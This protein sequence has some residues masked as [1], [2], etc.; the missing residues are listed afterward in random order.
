MRNRD[1]L[2]AQLAA[3]QLAQRASLP[4]DDEQEL[5]IAAAAP[6]TVTA[7]PDG[8]GEAFVSG[9]Q[10]L[11]RHGK[12]ATPV[13]GAEA[14]RFVQALRYLFG[15]HPAILAVLQKEGQIPA[16]V[17]YF[18]QQPGGDRKV[19]LKIAAIRRDEAPAVSPL[20][21][22]TPKPPVEDATS[23]DDLVDRA[24]A[25]RTALAAS[26]WPRVVR[27]PGMA[28]MAPRPFDNFLDISEAQLSGRPLPAVSDE[29]KRTFQTDLSVR[30]LAQAV[31]A[32]GP[33][34]LRRATAMLQTLR[35]Q[36]RSRAYL[37][38]VFEANDRATL[39]ERDAA[40]ALFAD[41]LRGNPTLVGAYKDIGDFYFRGFDTPHA[42]RSWNVARTLAPLYPP[43]AA[44]G[45]YER[46]LTTRFPEYFQ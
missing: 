25:T 17:T 5:S 32:K 38:S 46:S 37:L 2:R 7:R 16:N 23:L 4:L 36:A 8:A 39:G 9:D 30:M 35:P 10:V 22:Y 43:L 45:E 42:W 40:R 41:A 14:V 3:A 18:F 34:G 44:V 1:G 19:D 24:W 11:L 13:S 6:G 20:A 28:V 27:M 26:P 31:A 29:Q 15:G 33:E 12:E 21:G